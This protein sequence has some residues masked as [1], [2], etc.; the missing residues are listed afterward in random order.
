VKARLGFEI[1][2]GLRERLRE[3]AEQ[4]GRSQT[5]L[6]EQALAEFLNVPLA[7]RELAKQAVEI[8]PRCERGV[9]HDNRCRLCNWRRIDPREQRGERAR[10]PYR[11]TNPKYT[12]WFKEAA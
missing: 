11:E 7:N 10:D 6:I 8:C 4:T 5:S 2:R 1:H 3:Y 12:K 9:M